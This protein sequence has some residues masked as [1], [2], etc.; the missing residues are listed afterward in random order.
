MTAEPDDAWRARFDLVVDDL[1]AA[2]VWAASDETRRRQ[3][4][5]LAAGLA[6]RCSSAVD[7][8]RRSI[9]TSSPPSSNQRWQG[10]ADYLRMA[11][12][13]ASSRQVGN[14][15]LRLLRAAA[16]VAIEVGDRA[17]RVADLAWMSIYVDRFP[18][19][20]AERPRPRRWRRFAT[21]PGRSPTARPE[22]LPPSPWPR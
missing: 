6:A 2:L 15:A 7:R 8:P 17:V 21:R 19:F 20:L 9:V 16:D 12:G 13:A 1:R 14:E 22:R 11:A 10:A 3:A 18:G 4:A 5:E